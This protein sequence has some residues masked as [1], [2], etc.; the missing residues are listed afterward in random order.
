MDIK[1]ETQMF[2]RVS[3]NR[4]LEFI[5]IWNQTMVEDLK[6]NVFV[7]LMLTESCHPSRSCPYNLSE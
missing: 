7:I 2:R 5:L 4:G 3:G 6:W 1:G